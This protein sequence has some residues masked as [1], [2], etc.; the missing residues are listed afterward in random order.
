MPRRNSALAGSITGGLMTSIYSGPVRGVQGALL[1][2]AIAVAGQLALDEVTEVRDRKRRDLLAELGM[3]GQAVNNNKDSNNQ[4][5]DSVEQQPDDASD[6]HV[7]KGDLFRGSISLPS[8]F[9]VQL[10][11]ADQYEA[12][13]RSRLVEIDQILARDDAFRSQGQSRV[14]AYDAGVRQRRARAMTLVDERGAQG[15]SA[16]ASVAA[17]GAPGPSAASGSPSTTTS[18]SAS[19]QP[20]AE[21]QRSQIPKAAE[22]VSASNE[23]GS[24]SSW[25][26]PLSGW[27]GGSGG[28]GPSSSSR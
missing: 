19:S 15:P 17:G 9:P 24:P 27:G 6:L 4:A 13:L 10:Q 11:S 8:W 12:G 25:W 3:D 16:V 7:S 14:E 28:G 18:T 23:S 20:L 2:G 21:L 26:W 1:W 22:Q 5:G